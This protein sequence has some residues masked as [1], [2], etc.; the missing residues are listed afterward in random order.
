MKLQR[1]YSAH[2]SMKKGFLA[3]GLAL[4]PAIAGICA[5]VLGTP[6]M[7]ATLSRAWPALPTA[8]LVGVIVACLNWIK[9]RHK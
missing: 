6:D 1:H 7:I 8:T 5:T 2:V 9:N 3:A 4:L